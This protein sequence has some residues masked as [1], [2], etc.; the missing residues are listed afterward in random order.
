MIKVQR[1]IS[2]KV[3][4]YR[5]GIPF[6][7]MLF[8]KIDAIHDFHKRGFAK[9]VFPVFI[10]KLLRT[11]Y[12]DSYQPVV[13]TKKLTPLVG[14]QG[15]VSLYAVVY[16]SSTGIFLLQLH[17]FFVER[18]WTHQCLSSV[19]G[20]EYLRHGLR[21][22]VLLDKLFKQF[23]AHHMFGIFLIKPGLFQIITIITC[24]V[25]YSPYGLEHYV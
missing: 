10:M 1:I 15:S 16:A 20:E 6:Y 14:Q 17:C 8:Q 13:F 18:E 12:R 25:A 11:V 19:P 23:I 22:D 4:H 24:K 2:I 5:H 9:L 7:S 3:I 21:I